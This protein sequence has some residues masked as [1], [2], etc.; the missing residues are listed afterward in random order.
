MLIATKGDVTVVMHDGNIGIFEKIAPPEQQTKQMPTDGRRFGAY[1]MVIAPEG[2]VFIQKPGKGRGFELPGGHGEPDDQSLEECGERETI[3]EIGIHV[4]PEQMRPIEE[5]RTLATHISGFLMAQIARL[6]KTLKKVGNEGE[7][8][9]VI[10]TKDVRGA[11]RSKIFPPHLR[12][13]E[14]ALRMLD[15]ANRAEVR[16]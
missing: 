2:I 3:E 8:V 12:V 4:A 15:S 10:R 7:T 6:P 13:I 1:V 9:H 5:P 16:L 11:M 14:T